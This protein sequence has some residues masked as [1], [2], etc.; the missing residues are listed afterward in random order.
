[1]VTL[2]WRKHQGKWVFGAKHIN[3]KG[4]VVGLSCDISMN[5]RAFLWQDGTMIDLNT[6][7]PGGGVS[8]FLIEA[9]AINARGQ[10]AVFA[11][12]ANTGNLGAF[13]ATPRDGEAANGNT[14]L[15]PL[16]QG[17]Q[18]PPLPENVRNWLRK[19]IDQRYHMPNL[20]APND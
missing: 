11:F 17:S 6:L 2:K 12:D 5:C 19:R 7:V 13:L 10:F 8:I 18:N 9:T 20:A 3:N 14:V 15:A 1:M 16:H 4:Q